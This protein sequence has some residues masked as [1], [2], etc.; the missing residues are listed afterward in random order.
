YERKTLSI[1]R[2]TIWGFN[3]NR[4]TRLKAFKPVKDIRMDSG[5]IRPDFIVYDP[6][7][8][9]V[10][11]EVMGS[12]EVEYMERKKKTVPIMRRY[13]DLIEF[14]AYQADQDNCFEETA[15]D[16]CRQACRELL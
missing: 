12:H 2:R 8:R 16:A 15:R 6:S 3:E 5:F 11:L 14:D 4:K 13:C 10:I 9:N 1:L 7:Y